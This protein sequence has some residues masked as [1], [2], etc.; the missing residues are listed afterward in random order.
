MPERKL[1]TIMEELIFLGGKGYVKY[2]FLPI[3]VCNDL[4]GMCCLVCGTFIHLDCNTSYLWI[5]QGGGESLPTAEPSEVN[6][7]TCEELDAEGS[8]P[9]QNQVLTFGLNYGWV[10]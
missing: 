3:S 4:K 2:K 6:A 1:H 9:L 7:A 5:L 10:R 8:P